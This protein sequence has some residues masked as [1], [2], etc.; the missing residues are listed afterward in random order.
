MSAL[1]GVMKLVA[2]QKAAHET[3]K[4]IRVA[5]IALVTVASVC[6]AVFIC[7]LIVSMYFLIQIVHLLS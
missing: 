5:R 2:G 7:M 3:A 4:L 6:A 1:T